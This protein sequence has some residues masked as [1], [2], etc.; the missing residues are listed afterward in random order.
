[1]KSLTQTKFHGSCWFKFKN[2]IYSFEGK[3]LLQDRETNPK[4]IEMNSIINSERYLENDLEIVE[5]GIK[6]I[7]FFMPIIK[8]YKLGILVE[9]VLVKQFW[10][11]KLF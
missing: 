2:N 10:W 1:M 4:Y 8:G 9:L 5:T 7:D 3:P 11:K 6:A